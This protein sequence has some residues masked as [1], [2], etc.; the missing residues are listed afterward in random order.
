MTSRVLAVDVGATK[1][2]VALVNEDYSV[3]DKHEI[4]VQS[5]TN[6]WDQIAEVSTELL[7]IADGNLLG[8]G[9]GS[10]GPLQ[11]KE[12]LL[13][14]VNI[15]EW[16][17]FP[18]V[19][20]F[21]ALTKNS[22]VVLH[23]DAMAMVHAESRLGAGIG[24][25]NLL[26]IVVST[27]IGG[28]LIL[29]HRLHM[30]ETGNSFFIGHHTIDFNG[31]DCACGRKG[32]LEAYASGPRMVAI[33]KERGW[34]DSENRFEAL[35]QS[36]REGDALALEVIDQGAKALAVGIVN[37]IASLDL[38][39]VVVGGGVAQAGEIYWEPLRRHIKSESQY[40]DFLSDLDLR[41]AKLQ[42]DAG[43]LGAALGI[44]D[45]DASIEN[46]PLTLEGNHALGKV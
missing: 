26:G 35:A 2:A 23:G 9:I 3:Q 20:K 44:F 17:K 34:K 19:E 15:K 22:N 5:D 8:V 33:A 41:P 27:G 18:I 11:Q 24:V 12:G 13:S 16:R 7:K 6:L 4:P 37:C 30:G 40:A 1:V 42:R 14:P 29:D 10:A 39:T 38:Q 25:S 32:C 36:A 28:G 31:F 45:N 46:R 21:A 43:I